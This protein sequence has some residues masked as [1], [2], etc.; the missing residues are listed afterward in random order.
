MRKQRS[1]AIPLVVVAVAAFTGLACGGGPVDEPSNEAP[2]TATTA[3]DVAATQAPSQA[4]GG[5][6]AATPAPSA[7]GVAAT[8]ARAEDPTPV[9]PVN[10]QG[11]APATPAPSGALLAPYR[12][13][14]GLTGWVNS[15]PLTISGEL[16]RGR[17]VLIDFWTYTCINCIRTFPYLTAWQERYA[18]HGLTIIGVHSPEFEFERSRE[19][20]AAAI[21]KH[22]IQY[23]VAQD[24]DFATWRAFDN[25]FWPA[26]YLIGPS[27]RLLYQHF[28]EGQYGVTEGAIRQALEVAGWDLT[29]VPLASPLD[30]NRD[31]QAQGQTREL[32]GGFQRNYAQ[33]GNY[34]GQDA[35]YLG[36]GSRLFEDDGERR[37]GQ[38]F[39]QGLWT[40]QAEAIVHARSTEQLEDYI[41]LSFR[42]RSVNVVIDPPR[43]EPLEVVIELDGRP[44]LP[45]E[46]GAD[47]VFTA[48]GSSIVRVSEARLYALVELP[49]WGEHELHLRSNSDNLAIFAFT[50]GSYMEGS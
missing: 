20:V 1:L 29:D 43:D 27:G 7:D 30:P 28:G 6:D 50:F 36:Q 35:Y 18:E 4:V 37:D 42:A 34:A 40:V 21:A 16:S 13:L 17:V 31:P 25:R 32:Y 9:A 39:A 38:W 14:T 8:A 19:N 12:E 45:E 24:N 10:A 2:A 3:P 15:P 22:G 41:A 48:G 33:N 44:L 23:P 5:T 26:K 47:I 46:A 11:A 49:A